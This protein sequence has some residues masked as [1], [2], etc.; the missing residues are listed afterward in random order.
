VVKRGLAAAWTTKF[1]FRNHLV[2]NDFIGPLAPHRTLLLLLFGKAGTAHY[3][4][5]TQKL[6]EITWNVFMEKGRKKVTWEN[7][8]D[9]AKRAR[10]QLTKISSS[11]RPSFSGKHRRVLCLG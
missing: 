10:P 4:W 5:L 8:K 1:F 3:W 11:S 7:R 9:R 2:N 6:S